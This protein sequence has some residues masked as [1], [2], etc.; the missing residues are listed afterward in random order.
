MSINPESQPLPGWE[1][2]PKIAEINKLAKGLA[3]TG[4]VIRSRKYYD[5]FFDIS[6]YR[7][8]IQGDIGKPELDDLERLKA[9]H[10]AIIMMIKGYIDITVLPDGSIKAERVADDSTEEA[11]SEQ[12]AVEAMGLNLQTESQAQLY[13][14]IFKMMAD[15]GVGTDPTHSYQNQDFFRKFELALVDMLENRV[16]VEDGPD[17]IRPETV[18]QIKVSIDKITSLQSETNSASRWLE[19]PDDPVNGF[20]GRILVVDSTVAEDI[21][22]EYVT[23]NIEYY[24]EPDDHKRIQI[25]LNIGADGSCSYNKAITKHPTLELENGEIQELSESEIGARL[26]ADSAKQYV[27]AIERYKTKRL[28]GM[29]SPSSE[30]LESVLAVLTEAADAVAE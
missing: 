13:A 21:S 24:Y 18:H 4:Q 15:A 20:K 2:F 26:F 8:D 29:D 6:F 25:S 5:D 10:E 23:T 17:M 1:T 22:A 11:I 19:L 7:A 9:S 14:R 16:V 3:A 28:K 12:M 30:Q 27:Q